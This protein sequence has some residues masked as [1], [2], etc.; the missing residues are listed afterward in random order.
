MRR[1][2]YCQKSKAGCREST[3]GHILDGIGAADEAA[4]ARARTTTISRVLLPSRV[5]FPALVLLATM[6]ARGF[7]GRS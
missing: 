3:I 4:P 7:R 2:G 1:R 5:R 6:T